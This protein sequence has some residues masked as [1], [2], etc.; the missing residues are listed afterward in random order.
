[1][2]R[3]EPDFRRHAKLYRHARVRLTVSQW[4]FITMLVS[5]CF[6]ALLCQAQDATLPPARQDDRTSWP[7]RLH[8][9]AIDDVHRTVRMQPNWSSGSLPGVTE[10]GAVTPASNGSLTLGGGDSDFS[11]AG[12]GD[13]VTPQS[14]TAGINFTYEGCERM[15]VAP[16]FAGLE[17]RWIKPGAKLQVMIPTEALTKGSLPVGRCTLK[18]EM[19]NFVYL[20][21]PSGKLIRVSEDA[22]R[23]KPSLRT[24]LSG[25]PETLRRRKQEAPGSPLHAE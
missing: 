6:P 9:L 13:L 1:M 3:S 16:G 17:A 2:L 18:L 23:K 20:R 8:V 10:D 15:R 5:C 19:Q 14:G 24:F 25:G 22:Y 12:R 11:G 7:L 4:P 21:L